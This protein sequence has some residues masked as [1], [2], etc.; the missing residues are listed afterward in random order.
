MIYESLYYLQEQ[1]N[2]HFCLLNEYNESISSA[3][4][5][6]E[7]I[8]ILKENDLESAEN[9]YITLVNLTEESSLKNLPNYKIEKG[10]TIYENPPVFLNLFV[11]FSACFNGAYDKS[12]MHL[13]HLVAFFQSKN[14]FTH[15]NSAT[16]IFGDN[17][18]KLIMDLYSTT[19]EQANYLWSTLGGKQ[20]P[21]VLYKLRIAEVK[22]KDISGEGQLISE[23]YI[24]DTKV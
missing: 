3:P 15:K 20:H 1:L 12:L 21:Y 2:K 13:S 17:E 6:L 14:I 5:K 9:I 11:L 16:N 19:F 8:A 4:F 18:F 7:N 10:K 24:N 23:I 22:R